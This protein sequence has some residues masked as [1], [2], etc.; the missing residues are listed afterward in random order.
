MVTALILLS[1]ILH[2]SWN[3]FVK[4]DSDRTLSM[5]WIMGLGG[6]ATA[7]A[8]PFVGFPAREV[9][10][11]LI[12]TVILQNIYF[13]FV[14]L[15]YRHGDLSQAYPI[16]RGVAALTAALVSSLLGL[17]ILVPREW[18]GIVVSSLGIASLAFAAADK[19]VLLRRSIGYPLMSGVFT[20]AYSIVD[21]MGARVSGNALEYVLWMNTLAAPFLPAYVL[22]T[23][24]A[25]AF[26]SAPGMM[27]PRV[28]AALVAG[29]SYGIAVWAFSQ[30][31]M[32]RVAVLRETSVLFA[33]ILGSVVLKE[34]FGKRRII[35]AMVILGGFALW[36]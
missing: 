22:A 12:V 9:W 13:G 2:A 31:S 29:V 6:A 25:A 18:L 5:A 10:P 36:P 11:F 19:G 30:G 15:S 16:A 1:A 28:G 32:G 35:S 7:L 3:A 24:G 33:A 8:L 14:I 26:K 17:D 20:A 27:A 4:G 34:P 23:R 21:G